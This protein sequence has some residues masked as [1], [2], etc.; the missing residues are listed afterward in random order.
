VA[1]GIAAAVALGAITGRDQ[2]RARAD[3]DRSTLVSNYVQA[4]DART[5]KMP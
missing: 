4:L 5:M 3:A 1:G 2:A